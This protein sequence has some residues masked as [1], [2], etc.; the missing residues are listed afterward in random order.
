MQRRQW[1]VFEPCASP[2]Q[3][4]KPLINQAKAKRSKELNPAA[5]YF[6]FGESK[7]QKGP[8]AAVVPLA[9]AMALQ[10]AQHQPA[11]TALRISR[12]FEESAKNNFPHVTVPQN[13]RGDCCV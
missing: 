1:A 10:D 3:R 8:M 11:E 7:Q 6:S 2:A 13:H 9:T 4:A 5:C 12:L